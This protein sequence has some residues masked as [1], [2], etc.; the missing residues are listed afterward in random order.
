MDMK[1]DIQLIKSLRTID[2]SFVFDN[3]EVN[4]YWCRF[5]ANEKKTFMNKAHSHSFMELHVCIS[6]TAQFTF[7]KTSVSLTKG[8]A[9]LIP[10]KQ[11]HQIT[12]ITEDFVKL[13]WGVSLKGQNI[14]A[15]LNKIDKVRVVNYNKEVFDIFQTILEEMTKKDAEYESVIRYEMY[16]VL[17]CFSRKL[18]KN[19][20]DGKTRTIKFQNT[21]LKNVERY[22]VDNLSRGVS[23]KEL[24]VQFGVSTKQLCRIIKKEYGLTAQSFIKNIQLSKAKKYLAEYDL[25]VKEVAAKVGYSDRYTFEKAFKKNE[26]ISPANFRKDMYK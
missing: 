25:S 1:Y 22:V 17:L 20:D 12:D 26:G 14:C 21:R 7:G 2:F 6:G 9:I 15:L 10:A 3:L 16:R 13:V 5:A 23:V 11:E 8:Q 4:S 24:S 18:L 19:Y